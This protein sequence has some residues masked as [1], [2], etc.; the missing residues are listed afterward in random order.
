MGVQVPPRAR[1][2][3]GSSP[4]LQQHRVSSNTGSPGRG[5]HCGKPARRHTRPAN[6][7][8]PS[9]FRLG[10]VTGT[11]ARAGRRVH[12]LRFRGAH[13]RRRMVILHQPADAQRFDIFDGQ[14]RVL[15]LTMIG[16]FST[17]RVSSSSISV[18]RR[19]GSRGPRVSHQVTM[20]L[21]QGGDQPGRQGSSGVRFAEL[22]RQSALALRSAQGMEK[23]RR[24]R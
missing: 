13:L 24:R 1:S 5:R 9:D 3:V 11:A 12:P 18:A 7:C 23:Q 17:A 19:A 21:C 10:V 4:G 16:T 20:H 6:S 15:T 14:R 2:G 8:L 22:P